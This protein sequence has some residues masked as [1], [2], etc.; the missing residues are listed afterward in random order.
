M[1]KTVRY[2]VT[3]NEAIGLVPE[4]AVITNAVLVHKGDS[5]DG[6]IY[7]PRKVK[8]II[9]GENYTDSGCG[10]LSFAVCRKLD[11]WVRSSHDFMN[12]KTKD[13][14]FEQRKNK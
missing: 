6:L 11:Y 7:L 13:K 12:L 4:G 1:R 2:K 8:Y 9:D 5:N 10:C 3:E 14:T